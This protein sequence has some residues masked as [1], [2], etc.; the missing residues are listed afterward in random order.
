MLFI[1]IG[2]AIAAFRRGWRWAIA[3]VCGTAF[4]MGMAIGASGA[5]VEPPVFLLG[6]VAVIVALAV[7]AWRAPR[8]IGAQ[9]G[10]ACEATDFLAARSA[11]RRPSEASSA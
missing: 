3:V 8:G 1:Q 7:M 6:D 10:M 9:P 5:S 11:E 4:L 2:L